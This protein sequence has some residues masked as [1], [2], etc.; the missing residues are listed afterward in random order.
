M[1]A[2]PIRASAT[3]SYSSSRT[4]EGV[5]VV[6]LG[7]L[8]AKVV[9]TWRNHL[10]SQVPASHLSLRQQLLRD[11]PSHSA[12]RYEVLSIARRQ[13]ITLW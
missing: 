2:N 4:L 6:D 13:P 12:T 7:C 3:P 11:F 9:P 5:P 8:S 1:E 10:N